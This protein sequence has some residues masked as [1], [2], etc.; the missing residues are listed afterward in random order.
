[1]AK[2]EKKKIRL[3]VASRGSR[4]A[5]VQVEEF[6]SLFPEVEPETVFLDSFGDKH[7]NISLLHQVSSDFF[8]REL[9]EAVL[10]GVA[11]LAVHS[12]KD[13]PYP[14]P[15]GLAVV[16]L[17]R[18]SD[19]ADALVSAGGEPFAGLP[20]GAR[21]GTSSPLRRKEIL[22]LRPDVEIV[23]I[24]GTI[25]E[26]LALVDEG[27][28]DAL[29]VAACA[30]RRLGLEHRIT[31]ILPFATHPLQGK[32][33]VTARE[34]DARLR[35]L[36]GR[37]DDR[38]NYGRV[39]LVGFG[40]G[41]S[42]LLTLAGEAALR[43]AD[44]IFYDDLLD[45]SSLEKYGAEKVYVGKRKDRHSYEQ[46]RIN[47]LLYTAAAA[48]KNVVR[49]KGGDPMVFAHGREEIDFLQSRFVQ[50]S[51]VPGI[52]AGIALAA[53]T[54]IPLTHRGV[55]SSVAFLT[56]HSSDDP[57][58][59]D[60]DTLVY[61]MGGSNISRIARRLVESGRP[62]ELPAALV[63]NVS[64]P[65][66]KVFFSTIGELRESNFRYPTPVIV[67]IGKVVAFADGSGFQRRILVTGTTP[68]PYDRLGQVTHTPL[69]KIDR[70]VENKP[71]Y[72]AL[73][74]IGTF[75]WIVFTSR[76]GVRYFF[77]ALDELGRDIRELTGV[78]IASVGST[79]TAELALRH[80]RPEVES[81]TASA[82]GIVEHFR[83][84]RITDKRVL[85][86]RSDKG[87]QLLS[88]EMVK[89]GNK[90]YDIPVYHNVPT[91]PD[92]LPDLTDY[93]AVAFASPS[94]VEN[95][96]GLYPEIPADLRLIARGATTES[97]IKNAW[98][99]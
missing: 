46:H 72:A 54:G 11:D 16:A 40:P 5:K 48:G 96:S 60:A 74:K 86:P 19:P 41:S 56:G 64:M 34:D 80:I 73:R 9:D 28:V 30:L 47:E 75:H 20:A 13:L 76:Y 42:Q 44:V 45:H 92:R 82:E 53:C 63:Y 10:N 97:S 38:K 35:E 4:L 87:I 1:M 59:C 98:K 66:Q 61:Y 21:I 94:A 70:I 3:R 55:A 39:T 7:K 91:R 78:K 18:G 6:L 57:L 26:R 62:E 68:E 83:A 31:E 8:T 25:E 81:P 69:I 85:L 15:A 29:V 89:L 65:D 33:A 50:A 2:T 22:A 23:S 99:P 27:T 12:A 71:L 67:I 17:T 32:L 84:H 95:F 37:A 90:V 79:T 52:S 88:Q 43:D 77:E 36:F 49:L 14:L 24:R 51:V 93:D 58:I